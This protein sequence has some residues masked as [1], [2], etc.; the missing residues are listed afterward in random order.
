MGCE[1]CGKKVNLVRASVEGSVLTV[2]APCGKYG[3]IL[4]RAPVEQKVQQR[5]KRPEVVEIVVQNYSQIIR[6][7]RERKGMTQKEFANVLTEKESIIQK[8]ET[9]GFSPSIILARK[10]EKMLKISLVELQPEKV[11]AGAYKKS[12]PLTIGDMIKFK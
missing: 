2:C 7:A 11:A 10:L 5:A 4:K 6:K 12:G 8:M 3:R 9:D 1:L